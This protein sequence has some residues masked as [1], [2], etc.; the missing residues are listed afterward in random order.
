VIGS[1]SAVSP[2]LD[3]PLEGPVYL[4]TGFGH[5]LPDIVAD[6]RG[7]IHVVLDGRVDTVHSRLRTTFETVPDVPVTKF[8]LNLAGNQKGL[9]IS[10]KNICKLDPK[11]TVKMTGQNGAQANTVTT[12]D[13]P[14]GSKAKRKR[15]RQH[16]HRVGK[17]G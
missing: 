3:E 17:A 4:M 15:H 5:K 2:L 16:A 13:T 7:Q 9:L 6:L 10:S 12:L 8:V 14:C 11:A 1:A